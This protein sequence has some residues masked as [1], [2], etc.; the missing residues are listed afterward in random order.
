M[1]TAPLPQLHVFLAVARH[2]SFTGAAR[3]LGISPSAVSQSVKQLEATLRVVLLTR[4]TRSV[5]TTDAG[6]RLVENAGAAMKQALDA[7]DEASAKPG[8]VV[9]RVKVSVSH[10]A[11]PFVIT[12]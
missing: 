12:P 6:K 1:H 2:R 4:T 7:L 9:G 11:L 10:M 8:E 3:E 5:A